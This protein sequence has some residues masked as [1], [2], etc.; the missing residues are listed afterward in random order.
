[1]HPVAEAKDEPLLNRGLINSQLVSIS[2]TTEYLSRGRYGRI[3][4]GTN[5]DPNF[6]TTVAVKEFNLDCRES[7]ERECNIYGLFRHHPCIVNFYGERDTPLW[8]IMEYHRLGDLSS[9]L[10]RQALKWEQTCN[11]CLCTVKGK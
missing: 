8:L 4:L 10:E 6:P 5:L 3:H 1:M 2:S 11:I 9:V 7:K